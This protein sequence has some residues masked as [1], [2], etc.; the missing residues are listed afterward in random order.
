MLS[1]E[2]AGSNVV[3]LLANLPCDWAGQIDSKSH[4]LS[5]KVPAVEPVYIA[6]LE[7]KSTPQAYWRKG[8]ACSMSCHLKW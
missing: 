4:C 1:K 7:P 5:P 8:Q 2:E 6:K 3:A